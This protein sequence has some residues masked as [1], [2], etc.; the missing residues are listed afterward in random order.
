MRILER[1]LE[2]PDALIEGTGCQPELV[3]SGAGAAYA[4]M[5]DERAIDPD[6]EHRLAFGRRFDV[7]HEDLGALARY[8]EDRTVRPSVEADAPSDGEQLLG[9]SFA[10]VFRLAF[11][12]YPRNLFKVNPLVALMRKDAREDT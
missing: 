12:W 1:E 7:V 3:R 4:S 10:L 9:L 6:V 5:P 8:R 11:L 2:R